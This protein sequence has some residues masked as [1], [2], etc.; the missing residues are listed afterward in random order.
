M[1][2]VVFLLVQLYRLCE[3]V[4]LYICPGAATPATETPSLE[5]RDKLQEIWQRHTVTP[6][7]AKLGLILFAH[8]VVLGFLGFLNF[9]S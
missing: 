8:G 1:R 7:T 3:L 2:L 9:Y 4:A 6:V 5:N